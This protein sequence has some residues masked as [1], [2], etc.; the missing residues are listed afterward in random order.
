M[1]QW[2]IKISH[3]L[4]LK[5]IPSYSHPWKSKH[6]T[7]DFAQGF[8]IGFTNLPAIPLRS[9]GAPWEVLPENLRWCET[10]ALGDGHRWWNMVKSTLVMKLISIRMSNGY[11]SI[12]INTIFRGMNIHLPAI[13]MFTRGTR[14]W[15]TVKYHKYPYVGI[16]WIYDISHFGVYSKCPHLWVC[17]HNKAKG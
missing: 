8:P 5:H 11:G 13:L 1:I 14:F 6:G 4:F 2:P 10:Q 3:H 17:W 9:A 12:P 7:R 15:H 16:D